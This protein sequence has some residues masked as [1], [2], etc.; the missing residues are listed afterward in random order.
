M[1]KLLT[2]TKKIGWIPPPRGQIE[3]KCST[4]SE[5]TLCYGQWAAANV[6]WSGN[7]W[8]VISNFN[9]IGLAVG[10]PFSGCLYP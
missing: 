2:R 8:S 3:K 4:D 10:V 6:I 9:S 5:T 1:L 7:A